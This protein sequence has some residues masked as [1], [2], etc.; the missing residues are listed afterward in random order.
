MAVEIIKAI[1]YYSVGC[2]SFWGSVSLS[3]TY[4][5]AKNEQILPKKKVR[6]TFDLSGCLKRAA[7]SRLSGTT[8]RMRKD[9]LI[10]GNALRTAHGILNQAYFFI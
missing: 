1:L 9:T 8:S 6:M 2:I 10:L 4:R 3:N 5:P 7:L